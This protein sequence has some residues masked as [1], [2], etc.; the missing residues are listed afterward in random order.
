MTERKKWTLMFFFASDNILSPSM[1]SQ[2]K[3]IKSA[4]YQKDT[5]VVLHF[6][7]NEK[8]VPTRVFE[9]N[10]KYRLSKR[11]SSIG[12]GDG[13]LVS[14]LTSDDITPR[15]IGDLGKDAIDEMDAY[16]A[17]DR[18]LTVCREE[19]PADHYMLFLIGHGMIVGGDGFLPDDNP[20]SAIGLGALDEILK[21]FADAI[22]ADRGGVLELIGMH[23][24]SMSGVEIVYQLKGKANYIIASQGISF[25]GAWPYRQM[26]ITIFKTIEAERASPPVPVNV[27]ELAGKMHNLCIQHSADFMVGGYSAD[28]CLCSLK[29][30]NV[31]KLDEPIKKLGKALTD[32][33]D[34]PRCKHFI[35]LAHWKAQSY[36][37]ETYTDLY[38]FCLCLRRLCVKQEQN[39]HLQDTR[40]SKSMRGYD[41]KQKAIEEACQAVMEK[42]GTKSGGP[43]LKTDFIGAGSQYSHG[44]SVYFPWSEPVEDQYNRAFTNYKHYEFAKDHSTVHW[45][46]FLE[47]YFK[48]TRRL[49]RLQEDREFGDQDVLYQS[50]PVFNHALAEAR[51]AYKIPGTAAVAGSVG[52]DS[53][54]TSLDQKINPPDAG[55]A[56]CICPSIKNYTK[57]FLMSPGV[58][59]VFVDGGGSRGSGAAP[60]S[61]TQVAA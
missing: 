40:Q 55:G 27:L 6:D 45:L 23:S 36:W 17:L 43:V 41:A 21:T 47:E 58:A 48:K 1:L 18:F 29:E 26:L 39:R 2:I 60:D 9:V 11:E 59:E 53:V 14:V 38:D 44:L 56:A 50:D 31:E 57:D 5:N 30:A 24:C 10:Q 34:D 8:G 3:A 16:E 46:K 13:P 25:I 22:K 15:A 61:S 52:P 32:G 4:G 20:I 49:G 19:Y 33:L 37:Q 54:P 28:L 35:L 7:P 12:D 51:Q 42:L